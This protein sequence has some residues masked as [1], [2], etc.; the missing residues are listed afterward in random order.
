MKKMLARTLPLVAVTLAPILC[1]GL[2]TENASIRKAAEKGNVEAQCALGYDYSTGQGVP[3]SHTE[4]VKW[5]RKSAE[6]GFAPAQCA[7][8]LAYSEGHG[9]P[10]DDTV[11]VKWTR[12]SAEQGFAAAQFGLG[13]AYYYGAGVPQDQVEAVK[14]FRKAVEQ[15]FGPAQWGLGVAYY[16]GHGISQDYTAAIKW[17]RKSAEQ[18]F[19]PAQDALGVAYHEGHGVPQ[20]LSEAVKWARMAAEKGY[21]EARTNLGVYLAETKILPKVKAG[22]PAFDLASAKPVGQIPQPTPVAFEK[23]P[24]DALPLVEPAPAAT[25]AAPAADP[26]AEFVKQPAPTIPPPPGFVPEPPAPVAKVTDVWPGKIETPAP[27]PA[28]PPTPAAGVD[29][30]PAGFTIDKPPTPAAAP[31][32]WA[33][34]LGQVLAVCAM[35][36]AVYGLFSHKWLKKRLPPMGTINFACPL[37]QQ[38]LEA[39]A[40]MGGGKLDCPACARPITIPTPQLPVTGQVRKRS[41]TIQQKVVLGV[42]AAVVALLAFLTL[43]NEIARSG[44]QTVSAEILFINTIIGMLNFIQTPLGIGSIGILVFLFFN[45]RQR[46]TPPVVAPP[47]SQLS[48][49][50]PPPLPPRTAS[51]P[52]NTASTFEYFCPDCKRAFPTKELARPFRGYCPLCMKFV[53]IDSPQNMSASPSTIAPPPQPVPQHT[54][55]VLKN[56]GMYAL[57]LVVFI[58]LILLAFILLAGGKWVGDKSL[59][60]LILISSLALFVCIVI[61]GPLAF[62]PRTRASAA[63]GYSIASYIFGLTCW[64]MGLLTTW[65]LWGGVAVIVGL[66]IAGVGVVPMALLAA[67]FNGEWGSFGIISLALILTF[68][69]RFLAVYLMVLAENYRAQVRA[70]ENGSVLETRD[71]PRT[72]AY[73]GPLRFAGPV[74]TE[75]QEGKTSMNQKQKIAVGIGIAVVAA[76]LL[77]FFVWPTLYRYDH[78]KYNDCVFPVRINRITVETEILIPNRGWIS[79][80]PSP[81][82]ATSPLP[83]SELPK[84]EGNAKFTGYGD[85]KLSCNI[86]N[87]TSYRVNEVTVHVQV[88]ETGLVSPVIDRDYRLS[89][90]GSFI[91]PLASDTFSADAGFA[92]KKNQKWTWYIKGAAGVKH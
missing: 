20:D 13:G 39:P 90:Y 6:R 82:P 58:G 86:Y 53:T 32:N 29:T 81:G 77:G 52:K 33:Y 60:W 24:W 27:P 44:T 54:L 14:W 15:N 75:K 42:A 64:F 65:S 84:L 61:L 31:F 92:P 10:K 16:Q 5:F 70:D 7:L 28:A 51:Q 34:S 91:D 69:S 25:P 12:K 22:V 48:P 85:D 59:P 72:E 56:I 80:T 88:T 3:Q 73:F 30:L 67:L 68:G 19:A 55:S 36:L 45:F 1:Y 41:L 62:I 21:A 23:K 83:S 57:G 17:F 26:Y 4:A 79:Q 50:A 78:V 37:C 8:G 40:D 71:R 11:F 47:C 43:S 66:F 35:L 89:H 18:G 74:P 46:P 49:P 87:G 63:I 9:V 76:G 2:N 38:P